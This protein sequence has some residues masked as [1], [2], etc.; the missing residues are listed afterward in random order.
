MKVDLRGRT[1][2]VVG[3]EGVV[4]AAIMAALGASGTL[5]TLDSAQVV[6]AHG[7]SAFRAADL[8]VLV[9]DLRP[10]P[11]A[12]IAAVARVAEMVGEI[13]AVRGSGRIVEVLSALGIM[14]SRRHPEA[15]IEMATAVAHMRTLAMR[16]G[17]KVL[18]NAIGV[19]AIAGAA[20]ADGLAAGSEAMLSHI[21][22]SRAGMPDD[23]ANAVLFACDPLNSYM[24]GQVLTVDGGWSVG[25]GRNF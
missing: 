19:G 22:L 9:H 12:R 20:E 14:P 24:T 5:V 10:E 15:S 7:Q 3:E 25:Y 13:M 17:P 4:A 21:P 1:A 23:V 18:V 2:L 16:L 6:L 8:L 11:S